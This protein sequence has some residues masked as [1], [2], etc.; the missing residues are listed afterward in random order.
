VRSSSRIFLYLIKEMTSQKRA[1]SKRKPEKNKWKQQGFDVQHFVIKS[2][3]STILHSKE[4]KIFLFLQELVLQTSKLTHEVSYFANALVAYKLEKD[5]RLDVLLNN[6]NDLS[7]SLQQFYLNCFHMFTGNKKIPEFSAFYDVYKDLKPNVVQKKQEFQSFFKGLSNIKATVARQMATNAKNSFFMALKARVK[8]IMRYDFHTFN[9]G[10]GYKILLETFVRMLL[11]DPTERND[12][13]NIKVKFKNEEEEKKFYDLL[14]REKEILYRGMKKNATIADLESCPENILNYY[15]ILLQRSE[16]FAQKKSL[17]DGETKLPRVKRFSYLPLRD[18]QLNS[19]LIDTDLL[20]FIMKRC[21]LCPMLREKKVDK[22]TFGEMESLYWSNAFNV[23]NFIKTSNDNKT[24]AYALHTDGVQVSIHMFRKNTKIQRN[25]NS[26]TNPKISKSPNGLY[27]EKQLDQEV[28]RDKI[29]SVDPGYHVMLQCCKKSYDPQSQSEE[30]DNTFRLTRREYEN[31]TKMKKQR[32]QKERW[33]RNNPNLP[34][35]INALQFKVPT[36]DLMKSSLEL[37]SEIEDRIWDHYGTKRFRN[38]KFQLYRMKQKTMDRFCNLFQKGSIVAY[39]SARFSIS[40]KGDIRVPQ[41]AW[42][43]KLS[44]RCKVVLT[45]ERYTT[46]KCFKC[47]KLTRP[48][49]LKKDM[50]RRDLLNLLREKIGEKMLR[51]IQG[52]ETR[53]LRRCESNGCTQF[54]HRDVNA[55]KNIGYALWYRLARGER[56]SYLCSKD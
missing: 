30:E 22:K 14:T 42:I 54:L 49:E 5:Q 29:I 35:E 23:R 45:S 6:K 37:K 4:D 3:I 53:G 1:A 9:D 10:K 56:P 51:S 17:H 26:K 2:K 41:Q 47:K 19:I 28:I 27:F 31:K 55:A 8:S 33:A 32:A 36:F 24:F 39:G 44:K 15:K 18:Y 25:M 21:D 34:V 46:L 20:Y 43:S 13:D 12:I 40:K 11:N 16:D 7:Q 48:E 50:D 52:D 38:L